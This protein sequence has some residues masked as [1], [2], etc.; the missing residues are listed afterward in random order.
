MGK[1]LF[2]WFASVHARNNPIT[3]DILRN[4]A[5]FFGKE[6]GVG[7]EFHYSNGWANRFKYRYGISNCK[8]SGK[9]AGVNPDVIKSDIEKAQEIIRNYS[10]WDVYN[11]DGTGLFFAMIA[12]QSLTTRH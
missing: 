2:L 4:K 9:S 1:E 3:Q 11:M 6:F 8:I 5:M 12:D 10:L 7:S